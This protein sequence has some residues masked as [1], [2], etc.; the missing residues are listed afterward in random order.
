MLKGLFA[1]RSRRPV[2]A[3]TAPIPAIPDFGMEAALSGLRHRG[4]KPAVVYDVGAAIGSWTA[5]A[6][7]FWPDS[8]FYCF[9][10]L[11]ERRAALAELAKTSPQVA[12]HHIGISD[13]DGALELTVTDDLWGSSFAYTGTQH[14]SVPIRQIATL[15]EVDGL[16]PPNFLKVDVQGFERRVLKGA[17]NHLATCDLVLLECQFFAFSQEMTTLDE[18]IAMMSQSGFVPYEIVDFLRRPLDGAMGQCDIIFVRRN[19]ELVAD[20]RWA[21]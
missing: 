19:H 17:G 12:V 15:I 5:L 6:A 1:K 2:E 16:P 14:R 8:R 7:A 3:P 21:A 20:R 18:P 4:Y 10:P 9:E 11:S 13:T